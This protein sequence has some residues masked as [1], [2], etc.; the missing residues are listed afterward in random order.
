P[1]RAVFREGRA[2][3]A[4][5]ARLPGGGNV[6]AAR[7]AFAEVLARA[8]WT[9]RWPVRLAGVRLGR[10][11]AGS[12]AAFAAGDGT[13]CLPLRA[14]PRLPSLLAVAAG[15]PVDLFGLYDGHGLNP[16]ALVA[17]GRLYAMPSQN[18]QPVLFQVA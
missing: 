15:R 12:Q 9:E 7:D 10:L 5:E 6:A 14:D 13:G 2:G 11:P 4:A 17:G 18:A 8:P 16:L 3:P 1:L